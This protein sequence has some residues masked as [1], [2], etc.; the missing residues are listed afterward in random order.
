[1]FYQATKMSFFLPILITTLCER[2]GV[3][4]FDVDKVLPMDSPIHLLVVRACFVSKRK[5]RRTSKDSNSR[6]VAVS[7]VKTPS[8]VNGLR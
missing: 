3:T 6:A 7:T 5:R 8:Q 4:L 1:M 2:A